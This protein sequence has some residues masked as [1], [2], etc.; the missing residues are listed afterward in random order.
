M[1]GR[2]LLVRLSAEPE[3]KNA[4][5]DANSFKDETR[6]RGYLVPIHLFGL[7][8][9]R[10]ADLDRP[11]FS[12]GPEVEEYIVWAGARE[13]EKRTYFVT[14]FKHGDPS[15]WVGEADFVDHVSDLPH[16]DSKLEFVGFGLE[17]NILTLDDAGTARVFTPN[18]DLY[19]SE[20]F[21]QAELLPR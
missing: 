4:R 2:R 15:L 21:D 8:G 5:I 11:M 20:R 7:P 6:S 3:D 17:T 9:A 13:R 10:A 1:A 12:F 19:D 16:P 14:G 18:G